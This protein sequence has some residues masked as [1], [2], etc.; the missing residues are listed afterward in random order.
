MH[1]W[2]LIILIVAIGLM[3]M[4]LSRREHFEVGYRVYSGDGKWEVAPQCLDEAYGFQEDQHG[5]HWGWEND[6]N[7]AFY[8][9]PKEYYLNKGDQCGGNGGACKTT[10][11]G[12]CI[13][14]PWMKDFRCTQGTVCVQQDDV[15][16]WRCGDVSDVNSP[17]SKRNYTE[18]HVAARWDASRVKEL[19]EAG[20]NVNAKSDGNWV[21]L[22]EAA[23][24]QCFE[25][26][27]HLLKANADPNVSST[28]PAMP[29]HFV[30]GDLRFLNLILS[31]PQDVNKQNSEGN[32]PLH[33]AVN[34]NCDACVE[35]LLQKGAGPSIKI[36][37][38]E[39][40]TPLQLAGANTNCKGCAD[41]MRQYL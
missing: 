40:K 8:T 14:W 7:C 6:K 19:I 33:I 9:M 22:H 15:T 31:K 29:I 24:Y 35:V 12:Q 3:A 13:E 38:K 23:N 30:A 1:L 26:M 11:Q 4:F 17:I 41:K 18:L 2:G 28:Y 16:I 25:C 20:A 34:G 21:P 5:R 32:T 27:E 37:N 10:G 36:A 39:G